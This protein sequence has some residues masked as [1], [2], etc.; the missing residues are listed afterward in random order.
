MSTERQRAP[1]QLRHVPDQPRPRRP[2]RARPP[3][4]RRGPVAL[5]RRPSPT[6]TPTRITSSASSSSRRPGASRRSSWSPTGRAI[7]SSGSRWPTYFESIGFAYL[8]FIVTRAEHRGR[9]LGGALY[10]ALR[11][12]PDR[13]RRAAG[14]S[15]KCRPTTRRRCP[16]RPHLKPN[17]PRL[18]F[19]ERYGAVPIVGTL[20]DQPIRPGNP[21]EPRLLYDPLDH[22]K[23][24][25]RRRAPRGRSE[26][27]LTHRYHYDPETTPTSRRSSAS[28]K[29][30]PVRIREPRYCR[31]P[32]TSPAKI[33]RR[34][35]PL[36]GLL[37][38]AA[39]AAPRP[40]ARLR[41]AAGAGRRD[42]QGARACCPTSSGCP[43]ATSARSR[44]GPSTT[45]TSSTTCATSAR[46]C[47][48][49]ELVYP[50]VFPIRRTDRPPHDRSR[51]RRLLL[52]RHVHA[53]E[54][55]RLQ[56]GPRRG[57]RRPL[58][59]R[60]D[61]RRATRW[62][63]ASA[64]PPGH[65][66][67]RDT[68]GGFCYFCNGAI[69]AQYLAAKLGQGRRPRR[70]LPPRQR[71]P[72]HLLRPVRRPDRLDPRPPELR[73][74][75]L[76]GLRRRG[77]RGRGQGLQ[78]QPAAARGRPRRPLPR[79]A[80]RGAG[81]R[82]RVQARGPGR[83]ARPRHRQGRPDRHLERHAATASSRS[84]GGSAA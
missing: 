10:E 71:H 57:E 46:S 39:R 47:P 66:A 28:V 76:L 45:P 9:G 58:R 25:A 77:R 38:G 24:L 49:G 12:G 83:L 60:G 68:Y 69:A 7:R 48:T 14:S 75:V 1:Q 5:A 17:K 81:D 65:H 59:R 55:R 35:H 20:Y 70:R 80:R 23:P 36:E 40:R 33:P 21:A 16:T 32:R 44:S 51:P 6:S 26:T 2:P 42:P 61:R 31:R 67:E 3:L 84:A 78:P 37:L 19:Y 18:K 54:P 52:H 43:S 56:G 15:S 72:G 4:H 73:L 62:S 79:G 34:L 74:P 53:A 27:I 30:S 11:A 13:P 41:R 50:Y 64:G 22:E 82:P 8:D 63:T 29:E